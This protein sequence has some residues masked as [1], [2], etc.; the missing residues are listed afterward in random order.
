MATEPIDKAM[1]L[2]TSATMESY[3]S[4]CGVFHEQ[5]E[6]DNGKIHTNV[7]MLSY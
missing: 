4:T 1:K 7:Q 5:D 6:N 3:Q 2:F